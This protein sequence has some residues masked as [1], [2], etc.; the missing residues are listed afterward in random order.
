MNK[1]FYLLLFVFTVFACHNNSEKNSA[2][3]RDK[4]SLPVADSIDP[5]SVKAD[6]YYDNFDSPFDTLIGSWTAIKAENI[7]INFSKDSTFEFH[8]Y[9][10]KLKKEELLT[11]R[12]EIDRTVLTLIYSDRPKQRFTFK[13][14]PAAKNEYRIS[15]STGYYFVKSRG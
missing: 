7:T 1:Y 6:D 11:G 12:F 13:Q 5:A 14:D 2:G 9:N 8:D 10:H 3:T 15:N 4:D